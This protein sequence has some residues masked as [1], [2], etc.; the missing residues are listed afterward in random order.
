MKRLK[1][2]I[3]QLYKKPI[4]R[5]ITIG[6][7]AFLLIFLFFTLPRTLFNRPTGTIVYASD[8]TLLG[9]RIAK[10]GQ[11]RF[12]ST[13]RLNEKYK[14]AV[15][16][17]E[18]NWFYWH[19]GI[20][21]V[22]IA[23]AAWQNIQARRVV[24]GGSTLTMQTIR[25]MEQA[26]RTLPQKMKEMIRALRLE[27][28]YSKEEIL[29]LYADNAPFG[30]NVVGI[31]AASWRWFGHPSAT[32]S[33]GEAAL[34]AVLPNSPSMMHPGKNRTALRN[35][36]DRLL[37]RMYEQGSINRTDYL[38]SLDEPIPDEPRPLPDMA[39]HLVAE[40]DQQHKGQ[41]IETTINR[42]WQEQAEKRLEAWNAEFRQNGIN[43]IAA[44]VIDLESNTVA[45]YCGNV[46]FSKPQPGNQVDVVRSSR[47]T[48]S[49]LKPFLYCARVQ[50]GEILQHTLIPDIP[51]SIQGFAPKNYNRGYDGAVPASN[52]LARSLNIPAVLML[53]DYGIPKFR[54]LLVKSGLKTINKSADYYGLSLILG[55]A[56][57]TLWDVAS[58]YAGMAKTLN[59]YND[60][61]TYNPIDWN[62]PAYRMAD[63]KTAPAQ[64]ENS[65]TPLLYDAGAIWQTFEVLSEVNRPE[66]M[67]WHLMPSIRKVAW[68]TGTSYGYRDAWAV[69]VT[70][71]FVVGV[72]VGN[73]SGEGKAG[74][75]GASTAAPVMFDLF[76]FLPATGWFDTPFEA[77][78]EVQICK[79]SGHLKGRFC[80]DAVT[81]LICKNGERT[82]PCPYH[83]NITVNDAATERI[84]ADCCTDGDIVQRTWF[85]LP[86]S[87][88][89]F[90]KN[91]HPDYRPLPPLSAS[92]AGK[93][94]GQAMQFIYPTGISA[95]ILPRQL[96]GSAGK[97]VVEVAHRD[98]DATLYWHWDNDFI[99]TT[100]H[101]HQMPIQGKSGR[102]HLVITD[103]QGETISRYVTIK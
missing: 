4:A 6:L 44:V 73:A 81:T 55:G 8:G 43:H 74:L 29:H 99:G 67:D 72:W 80:P 50:E 90:Y 33:W 70:P 103:S 41:R 5:F 102:H 82:Q 56:E 65:K 3:Y 68:K 28:T 25:L 95:I 36:R 59:R 100:R 84:F 54:D 21:P 58:A 12:A 20:N 101:F 48:G 10:D 75:T 2:K 51:I 13:P 53:R 52:A 62:Q 87:W 47:S 79:Q 78:E 66:E 14:Q 77:L 86:P 64:H 76:N 61:N 7:L 49:I 31:E 37:K 96:D 46:G 38:T 69:G 83:I 22:S 85:V 42:T 1:D 60:E 11:W 24:S 32:L 16:S 23:R 57:A 98:P 17:F 93:E 91:R 97:L 19:P 9:A 45:A 18:D 40:A 35:K 26:P 34:L 63:S 39:A 88:E 27:L 30:G 92:C 94:S 89:W 15:I 71:R